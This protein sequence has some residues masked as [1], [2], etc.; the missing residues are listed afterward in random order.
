MAGVPIRFIGTPPVKDPQTIGPIARWPLPARRGYGIICPHTGKA[1]VQGGANANG[2]F[3]RTI[4]GAWHIGYLLPETTMAEQA[5]KA[6]AYNL[7]PEHM[8]DGM[9]EYIEQGIA[10]GGFLGT[11]LVGDLFG[12]MR[13]A[14]DFNLYFLQ[15][16]VRF[17]D[18]H[19]PPACY[20][21]REKVR[22]WC[23]N[24]GLS[25]PEVGL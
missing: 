11:V 2:M 4:D 9:R 22:A 5:L 25:G 10:P 23:A 19:A 20:G 24:G 15:A 18:N 17:L 16:Y 6:D 3:W 12:A 8:R 21:S 7:L 14:D 1:V 13:R